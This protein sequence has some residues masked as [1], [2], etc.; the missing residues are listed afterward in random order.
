MRKKKQ[1]GQI[2]N[3]KDKQQKYKASRKH[4]K[5]IIIIIIKQ[6][7]SQ[8]LSSKQMKRMKI[9]DG[10]NFLGLRPILKKFKDKNKK[11]EKK[12]KRSKT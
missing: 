1:E 7:S 3:I 11:F 4:N 12:V 6:L 5:I 10:I 2:W 9:M 8:Q